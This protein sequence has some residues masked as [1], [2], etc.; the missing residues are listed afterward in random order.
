MFC[1]LLFLTTNHD[2]L[3]L[4]HFDP[5]RTSLLRRLLVRLWG[6]S[7]QFKTMTGTLLSEHKLS[8]HLYYLIF[9]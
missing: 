9:K 7:S 1:L 5:F 6:E 2:G 8:M 3:F 4:A